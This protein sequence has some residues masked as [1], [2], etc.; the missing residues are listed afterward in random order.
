GYKYLKAALELHTNVNKII[1]NFAVKNTR[2]GDLPPFRIGYTATPAT[3]SRCLDTFYPLTDEK[4]AI[5]YSSAWDRTDTN[6]DED[7]I[8]N[9]Y[10]NYRY[11]PEMLS[12]M[13]LDKRYADSIFMMRENIGGETLGM[14]RFL[15]RIDNWPVLSYARFLIETNRIEKYLLLLFAHAS[16]HG[17]PDLMTYHEQVSIDGAAVGNDC[18]PSLL[19]VP[20]ML[21]WCF[22]YE[23]VEGKT[24]RLL[25]ALPREWYNKPFEV[26]GISFSEGKI[27]M[28]Y[29][30]KKLIVTFENTPEINVELV[31]RNKYSVKSQDITL[32]NEYIDTIEGNV[33]HLKKG[34]KEFEI[35]IK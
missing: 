23:N 26:K 14:T 17:R 18:I 31:L 21:T 33:L 28:S 12:S 35:E 4:R 15:E 7:L 11:Y 5:Y 8:E 34:I 13:L 2:F 22:A 10:A 30:G 20:V 1:D 3:L 19:T 29:N 27:D 16:H 9:S 32:G 25:S 6:R 24:L